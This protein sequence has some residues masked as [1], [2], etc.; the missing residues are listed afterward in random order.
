MRQ[1]GGGN[2]VHQHAADHDRPQPAFVAADHQGQQR[3]RQIDDRNH[4]GQPRVM[5]LA[6]QAGQRAVEQGG[7]DGCDQHPVQR[8]E[9]QLTPRDRFDAVDQ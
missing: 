6:D 7:D 9:I 5:G 3:Q 4:I 1:Q 8:E 2:D